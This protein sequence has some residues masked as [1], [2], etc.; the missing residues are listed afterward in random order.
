MTDVS[1]PHHDESTVQ[2]DLA[3]ADRTHGH[4]TGHYS[5]EDVLEACDAEEGAAHE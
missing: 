2:K 3:D 4:P 1:L 5:R